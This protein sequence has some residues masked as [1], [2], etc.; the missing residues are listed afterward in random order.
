MDEESLPPGGTDS[1]IRSLHIV[2]PR[3]CS[4][5]AVAP[6]NNA[7]ETNSP[8]AAVRFPWSTPTA[9]QNRGGDS[10][11]ASTKMKKIVSQ[12]TLACMGRR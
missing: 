5:A 10:A 1:M 4:A 7:N 11:N 8:I 12:P 2:P 9:S 3:S 6:S